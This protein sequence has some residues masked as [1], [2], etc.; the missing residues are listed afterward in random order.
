MRFYN[1][2]IEEDLQ[3]M[4]AYDLTVE[5]LFLVKLLFLAKEENGRQP[6]IF[7]YFI[8]C[9]HNG[10]PLETLS[11]LA[12]KEILVKE[13]LPKKGDKFVADNILFKDSFIKKWFVYSHHAGKE[14]MEIYPNYM[15]LANGELLPAKNISKHYNSLEAFYAA[16]G[17]LIKHSLKT[18]E[19]VL[20]LIRWAK[21]TNLIKYGI[22]EFVLSKKWEVLEDDYQKYNSGIFEGTYDNKNLI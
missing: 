1:T 4:Q 17:K 9:K 10:L 21:D 7:E 16:Y 11:H 15:Q 14:L 12:E 18:H 22:A 3:L 19:K 6:H 5:E 13:N 20:N 8:K 2:T